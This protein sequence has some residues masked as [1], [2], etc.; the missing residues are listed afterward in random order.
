MEINKFTIKKDADNKD[1]EESIKNE[2]VP[3]DSKTYP[4]N[5]FSYQ[6]RHKRFLSH[7]SIPPFM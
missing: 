7:D 6:Y 5:Y 4:Y 1:R 2:N 3:K